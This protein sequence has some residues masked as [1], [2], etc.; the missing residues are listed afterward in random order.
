MGKWRR[1]FSD[2]DILSG[3][4]SLSVIEIKGFIV[5]CLIAMEGFIAPKTCGFQKNVLT[6]MSAK[7]G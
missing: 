2:M 3:V 6:P 7:C 5:S 4:K 1:Y